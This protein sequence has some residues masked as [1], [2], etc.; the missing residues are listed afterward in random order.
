M[1]ERVTELH[2]VMPGEHLE[3]AAILIRL[4]L[5]GDDLF[6]N[7]S[8]SPAFRSKRSEECANVIGKKIW[9]LQSGKMSA[10][11]HRS[12]AGYI[13]VTHGPFLGRQ[14]DIRRE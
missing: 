5:T 10:A 8:D 12:P 4:D 6:R 7:G 11:G 3:V 14:Q 13:Q 2:P 9:F 1:V